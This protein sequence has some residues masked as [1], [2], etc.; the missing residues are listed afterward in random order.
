MDLSMTIS[1]TAASMAV[2]FLRPETVAKLLTISGDVGFRV[3][4]SGCKRNTNQLVQ[5][6]NYF[7]TDSING[8][9]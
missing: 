5:K 9:A 7:L 1:P 3:I 2:E 4:G 6:I 8:K